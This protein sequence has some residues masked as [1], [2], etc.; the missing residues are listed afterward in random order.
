M[1]NKPSVEKSLI[2]KKLVWKLPETIDVY[3]LVIETVQFSALIRLLLGKQTV[4]TRR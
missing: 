1:E 4:T 2:K 3:S